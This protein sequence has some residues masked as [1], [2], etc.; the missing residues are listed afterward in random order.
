MLNPSFSRLMGESSENHTRIIRDMV[1]IVD[2]LH[3]PHDFGFIHS[4]TSGLPASEVTALSFKDLDVR[5]G[6]MR[7]EAGCVVRCSL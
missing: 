7:G 2:H 1:D 6:Y 4:W 3:S 5:G